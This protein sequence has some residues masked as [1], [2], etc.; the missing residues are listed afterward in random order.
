MSSGDE[1][2]KRDFDSDIEMMPARFGADGDVDYTL[3]NYRAP[4]LLD[5]RLYLFYE[6]SRRM[7]PGPERKRSGKNSRSTRKA[8]P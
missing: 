8:L 4:L 7:T 6:G 3:D 1:L 5:G 2:W